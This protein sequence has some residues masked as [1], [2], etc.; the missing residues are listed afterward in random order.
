MLSPPL[1]KMSIVVIFTVLAMAFA[2]SV[3]AQE[4]S[5][6]KPQATTQVDTSKPPAP[7]NDVV[8]IGDVYV[9]KWT[10]VRTK[11]PVLGLGGDWTRLEQIVPELVYDFYEQVDIQYISDTPAHPGGV[12]ARLVNS[13]VTREFKKED[14]TEREVSK[15]SKNFRSDF[16]EK[17]K[18]GELTAEL[19]ELWLYNTAGL[20]ARDL[21]IPE[22][23]ETDFQ[24]TLESDRPYEL[25][26]YRTPESFKNGTQKELTLEAR[27]ILKVQD[28]EL[29][30][31]ARKA[32]ALSPF[33]NVRKTSTDTAFGRR[34][35]YD[36]FAQGSWQGYP[37]GV[38]LRGSKDPSLR[39]KGVPISTP[40]IE[41]KTF[42]DGLEQKILTSLG[43]NQLLLGA[44][45]PAPAASS[46]TTTSRASKPEQ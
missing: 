25:V 12:Y 22:L 2:I 38:L 30:Q 15:L 28:Q 6:P 34:K 20:L 44:A 16:M 31:I 43:L 37:V 23:S 29:A 17:W 4:S 19:I 33:L 45:K 21:T 11:N 9:S 42:A 40:P 1:K 18:K 8:K 32:A 24:D 39:R 7:S 27:A 10:G 35:V 26:F 14:L 41:G 5:P 3:P 46:S 13:G 36:L